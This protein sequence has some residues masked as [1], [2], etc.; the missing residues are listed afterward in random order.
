MILVLLITSI[1]ARNT[2]LLID[3]LEHGSTAPRYTENPAYKTTS[4][5]YEEFPG[6]LT[7]RGVFQ[8]EAIGKQLRSEYVDQNQL[9]PNDFKPQNFYIKSY[10]D[11][12]SVLSSYATMLGAYPNSVSWVQFQNQGGFSESPFTRDDELTIRKLL[13]MSNDPSKLTTREVTVWS[14]SNGRT[15]FNDPL[16]NCP[17]MHKQMSENLD[18]ANNKYTTNRRFDALYEEMEKTLGVADNT[19]NFKNAH[20]YLDDYVTSQANDRPVP[21]FRDQVAVDAQIQNYHRLYSYE[22]LYGTDFDLSR[23]AGNHFF[24]YVLTSMYGKYRTAKGELTNDHYEN[25]KYSQFIGNENAM[26]G[27]IKL[28]NDQNSEPIYPPKFGS[29]LRFELYEQGGLYFVKVTNNG[30]LVNLKGDRDGVIPYEEFMNMIYKLLYFGDVDKYCIGQESANGKDRPR[31][32]KYEEFIWGVNP[33]L[34]NNFKRVDERK[35]QY[36]EQSFVELKREPEVRV[37]EV[38]EPQVIT[39]PSPQERP[40]YSR[41]NNMQFSSRPR[42]VR[43]QQSRIIGKFKKYKI[44]FRRTA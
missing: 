14:E 10:K 41:E 43:P 7:A 9:L 16:N 29:T 6:E 36:V 24:T 12:P 17:Q 26:I 35:N 28:L 13:S 31:H 21:Q 44:D 2:I 32:E 42:E 18:I 38:V 11:E 15:L 19:L 20:L 25:L 40:I 4:N 3:L 30:Y 37:V 23:V 5:K 34:K 8:M 27:A 1:N 33:D 39:V 22:G